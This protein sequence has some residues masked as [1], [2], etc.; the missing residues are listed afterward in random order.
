MA[1]PLKATRKFNGKAY[2]KKATHRLKSNAKKSARSTRSTGGR[3][4]VTK[5]KRG[6]TVYIRKTK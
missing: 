5:S 4:R 2:R 1:K 6:W 3:A